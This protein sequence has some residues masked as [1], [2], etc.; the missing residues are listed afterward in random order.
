VTENQ[1]PYRAVRSFVRRE[2]RLT[3]AQQRALDELFPHY[4]VEPGQ[5]PLD[6]PTI[7][8]RRAPVVLDI[9]FGDGEALAEIA[10]NH[11]ERDYLGIEVHRPGVGRLLRQ[12]ADEAVPNVRVAAADAVEV[13]RHNIPS[14][15]LAGIQLFYPDPWPKKRHHKRRIVQPAW[16]ELAAS[17]LADEGFLH[18]TTDWT[19]YAEHM[20]E[21]VSD[22]DAFDNLAGEGRFAPKPGERPPTKFERRGRERGHAIHDIIL[23]RRPRAV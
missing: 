8:G 20:L 13:M 23:R 2:G 7:F 17:R 1:T 14:A 16:L 11:P 21:V 5:A 6:F 9:G 12:L 22:S 19:D 15:S 3:A 10:R 4:G 18:M